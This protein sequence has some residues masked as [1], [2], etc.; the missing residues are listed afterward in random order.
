MTQPITSTE[1]SGRVSRSASAV[2]TDYLTDLLLPAFNELRAAYGIEPAPPRPGPPITP[3]QAK[4]AADEYWMLEALRKEQAE[5][6]LAEWKAFMEAGAEKPRRQHKPRKPP[7]LA[8]VAEQF[9][10]ADIDARLEQ[11]PDGT[12]VVVTGTGEQQ[13]G[14]ELDEWIAKHARAPERHS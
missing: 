11:K 12:I 8:K 3:E 6:E 5:A 9:R 1:L 7:T 4:A 10:K 13:Q 14:N 2:L